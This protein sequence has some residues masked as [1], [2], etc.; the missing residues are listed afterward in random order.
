MNLMDRSDEVTWRAW[1]GTGDSSSM[2]ELAVAEFSSAA[3]ARAW[4]EERLATAASGPGKSVFGSIDRGTYTGARWEPDEVPGFDAD[5]VD[6]RV[7]WHRP[8]G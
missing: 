7:C 8:G 2:T 6:G 5:L 4:V 3:E 1:L